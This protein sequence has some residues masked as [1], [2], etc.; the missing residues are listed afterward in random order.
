MADQK[1]KQKIEDKGAEK[2]AQQ[3][4][5]AG[6]K[7]AAASG[8]LRP[9]PE[10]KSRR[11]FYEVG[12]KRFARVTGILNTLN[13]PALVGWAANTAIEYLHKEWANKGLH[14]HSFEIA[15]SAWRKVSKAAMDIGSEVHTLIEI[16]IKEG[17]DPTAD[18]RELKDEVI[19]AYVA[20]LEWEKANIKEWIISEGYVFSEKQ[21]FAGTR[22]AEAIMLDDPTG[23]VEGRADKLYLVDFKSSKGIYDEAY[24]QVAG[25]YWMAREEMRKLKYIP[26]NP[27]EGVGILRL[28]KFT[29][30]PEFIDATDFQAESEDAFK[31]LVV[32]FH[33]QKAFDEVKPDWRK[34]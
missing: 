24:L 32:F 26:N 33:A 3:T 16:H 13:K 30:I 4:A 15:K 17:I 1:V 14:D 25:A 9:M 27:L 23:K 5:A 8:K 2:A 29:G 12:G 11:S 28:D 10:I 22:D 18:G 34:K 31:K 19:N 21:K 20:F 6:Q 7:S